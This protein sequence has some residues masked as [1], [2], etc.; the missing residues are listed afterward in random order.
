MMLHRPQSKKRN[1]ILQQSLVTW[2]WKKLIMEWPQIRDYQ[3]NEDI[4]A[5]KRL[6]GSRSTGEGKEVYKVLM[7]GGGT[8]GVDV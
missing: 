2:Q 3:G 1:G 4:E 7:G 5:F 8:E 6:S